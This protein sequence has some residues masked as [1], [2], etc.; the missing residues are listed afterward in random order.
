[1]ADI[2]SCVQCSD[3]FER[4]PGTSRIRCFKCSPPRISAVGSKQ[5]QSGLRPVP[6]IPETTEPDPGPVQPPPNVPHEPGRHER[7]VQ[8][9]L[10]ALGWLETIEGVGVLGLAFALDDQWLPGAQRTSMFKELK[11]T[12]DQIRQ[13]AEPKEADVTDYW[14]ER[15]MERARKAG[16]A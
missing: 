7:V 1:V 2:R 10:E 4:A 14:A 9:E 12:M 8:A 13:L 11:S 3:P 15:A 5:A 16:S 6:A